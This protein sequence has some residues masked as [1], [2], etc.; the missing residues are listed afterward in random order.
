MNIVFAQTVIPYV[1]DAADVTVIEGA[2]LGAPDLPVCNTVLTTSSG[3]VD[4]RGEVEPG[5]VCEQVIAM[6]LDSRV[7]VEFTNL[8]SLHCGSGKSVLVHVAYIIL[9]VFQNI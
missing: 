1:E 4:V 3:S 9:P 5:V 7:S 8:D 6:P 2:E